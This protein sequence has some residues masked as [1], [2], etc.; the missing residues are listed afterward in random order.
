MVLV[1]L[2]DDGVD[3]AAAVVERVEPL[4]EAHDV[5]VVAQLQREPGP[6]RPSLGHEDLGGEVVD[7][8]FGTVGPL[9]AHHVVGGQPD[10]H[11]EGEPLGRQVAGDPPVGDR[12]AGAVRPELDRD[13]VH[14]L[15][16]LPRC[17]SRGEVAVVVRLAV[18]GHRERRRRERLDVVVEVDLEGDVAQPVGDERTDLD[19]VSGD[20]DDGH[21]L[22]QRRPVGVPAAAR[23]VP[24]RLGRG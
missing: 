17:R 1:L 4:P 20:R 8:V 12:L 18:T 21:A 19:D 5:L 16:L 15:D 22:V 7:E 13:R 23:G 10:A 2:E 11:L 14:A 3:G 24:D 9:D 6:D